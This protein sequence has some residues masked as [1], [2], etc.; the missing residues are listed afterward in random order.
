[1]AEYQ[2]DEE[3]IEALKNWWDENGKV[4]L[5]AAVVAMAA[6]F[7]FRTWQSNVQEQGETSSSLYQDLMNSV[8]IAPNETLDE[9]K[10]STGKYLANM[11]KQEHESSTYAKFAS[12]FMAQQAVE[13]GDLDTAE[14]EL[15]WVLDHDAEGSIEL[16]AR[17]RLAKVL[18][19]KGEEQAALSLI[20]SVE[21]G[22]HTSSY[23]ETKGDI[24]LHLGRR[25][26]AR[27]AYQKAVN[28]L[29]QNSSKPFLQMKLDDIESTPQ[30]QATV[31]PVDGSAQPAEQTEPEEI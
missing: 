2:T 11:L 20:G 29:A 15:R 31:E 27:S 28:A 6:V 10:V 21:A 24:Y 17:L 18:V 8:L 26:D 13:A 12:L 9:S 1:M 3:Q 5:M 23:E 19:E 14:K 25:D 7:G 4:L 30:A 22:A 16:V